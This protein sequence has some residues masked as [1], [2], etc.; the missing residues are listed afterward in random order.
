MGTDPRVGAGFDVSAGFGGPGEFNGAVNTPFASPAGAANSRSYGDGDATDLFGG[1]WPGADAPT[2]GDTATPAVGPGRSQPPAWSDLIG[3]SGVNG[4]APPPVHTPGDDPTRPPGNDP[5][6]TSAGDPLPQR[7]PTEPPAPEDAVPGDG[8]AIPRQRLVQPEPEVDNAA[9]PIA[10]TSF[11]PELSPFAPEAPGPVDEVVN[12]SPMAMPATPP[13]WPP[14]PQS[15]EPEVETPHVPPAFSAALDMTAEMP[16]VRVDWEQNTEHTATDAT[17]SGAGARQRF[18]DETMELPIFR[19]LESAWFRTPAPPSTETVA[20][21]GAPATETPSYEPTPPPVSAGQPDLAPEVPVQP[22]APAEPM[23]Q[24]QAATADRTATAADAGWRTAAD[25]GWQAA[26]AL[27]EQQDFATT[28]M[29]LPK[30]VPMSQLVPG[31]VEKGTV[32][33]HKRT[34]EAVRGLLSAYHRGVQRGRGSKS[35]D[36]KTPEHTT[37]GPQSSQGGKEQEA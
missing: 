14:V 20:P 33:A 9:A 6:R 27:S 3:G 2:S 12:R 15:V 32:S 29:G 23:A 31:G 11:A 16:R 5:I 8:P 25:E 1:S 19:E 34:P 7:R 22:P 10:P 21:N 36:A 13:A 4:S 30:R 24:P 18:A 28:P 35:G 26:S 17:G 37:A